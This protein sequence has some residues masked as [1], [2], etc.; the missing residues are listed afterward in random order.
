MLL[1]C[2]NILALAGCAFMGCV[3]H[4]QN[5]TDFS[6]GAV[7]LSNTLSLSDPEILLH[8]AARRFLRFLYD[9]L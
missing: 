1:Y 5:R 9:V 2:L 3:A 8:D 6:F 4:F 7:P